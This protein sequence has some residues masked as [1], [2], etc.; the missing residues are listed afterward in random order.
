MDFITVKII[1]KGVGITMADKSAASLPI[2]AR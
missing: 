2:F 1:G